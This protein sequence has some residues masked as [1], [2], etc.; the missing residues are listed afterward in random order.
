MENFP[1]SARKSED[2]IYYTEKKNTVQPSKTVH[3]H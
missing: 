2:I 3:V 1:K